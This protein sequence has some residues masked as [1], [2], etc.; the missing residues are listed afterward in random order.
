[1]THQL[2][3]AAELSMLSQPEFVQALD[4]IFEHSPWVAERTWTL[5]PFA[6]RDE[7]L[8]RMI[9]TM[10]AASRAEQLALIRA[11]PEL[12]GRAAIEGNLTKDSRNEQGGAGLTACSPAEFARLQELNAAYSSKFHHPFIMAVKGF[13]RTQIIEAFATRLGNTPEAEF[14]EC[15]RQIGRIAA[16]RLP[17]RIAA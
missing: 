14:V 8:A 15:L 12:A 4:G 17:D 1:M 16:L 9:D 7:L 2:L 13:T 5:R 6:N 3:S 10:N 11:H